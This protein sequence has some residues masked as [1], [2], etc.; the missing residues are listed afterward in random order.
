MAYAASLA[1]AGKVQH[2]LPHLWM[3][4]QAV[5]RFTLAP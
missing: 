5:E 3:R 2:C 4:G 1:E